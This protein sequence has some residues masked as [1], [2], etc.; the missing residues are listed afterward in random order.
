M[1]LTRQG[2][3]VTGSALTADAGARMIHA[4]K[5]SVALIDIDGTNGSGTALVKRLLADEPGTAS[6]LYTGALND[7]RIGEAVRSGARGVVLK[8]APIVEL[9][10]A[11]NAAASGTTYVDRRAMGIAARSAKRMISPR[12]AEVLG[13]L[14][15]GLTCRGA[16]AE[17]Q[18]ALTTVQTHVRNAV[19]KLGATGQ[20]HAV[21]LALRAGEIE[22]DPHVNG[23]ALIRQGL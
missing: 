4:R 7:R 11:I 8:T 17:L 23:D 19:R 13:L 12:E 16:A 18:L 15:S 10:A 3:R 14:V 2:F 6:V 5:P 21:V 9:V 1:L 22:L 20:L